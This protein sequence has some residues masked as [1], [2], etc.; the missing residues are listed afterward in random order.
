MRSHL[1]IPDIQASTGRSR[2]HLNWIPNVV[3]DLAPDVIVCAGDLGDF[4]SISK[5]RDGA[6]KAEDRRLS[7]DWDCFRW[8]AD[9]ITCGKGRHIFIEGNHED[10]VRRYREQHYENDMLPDPCGYMKSLGWEV[11]PYMTVARVDGVAYSHLFARNNQGRVTAT[12]ERYG[13][14]SAASMVRANGESCTAGHRQ[15]LEWAVVPSGKRLH[16]G[17]IAGSF[18][19][20]DEG[21]LTPQGNTYWRGIVHKKNVKNGEYT[22][23]F[24]SI[25]DLRRTYG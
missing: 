7:K 3:D 10:R 16:H 2:V 14:A 17:L 25:N 19:L 24:W 9:A 22:P 13:A 20:H 21:Y 23:T 8:A 6:L 4:N 11:Y 5:Y 18:Y 15:G 1:F 12:S